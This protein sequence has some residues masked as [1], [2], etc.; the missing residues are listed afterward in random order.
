MEKTTTEAR[1]AVLSA[2]TLIGDRVVNPA[3]ENLGKIQELMVDLDSSR[4]A[5]AVLGFG[6]FLGL[7]QKLIAIPFQALRLDADRNGFILDIDKEKLERAPAFDKRSSP[8]TAV[9]TWGSQI[10]GYYGY[11]PYWE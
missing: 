11:R 7:R 9:R 2:R 4:I 8:G 10:H 3:G 1:P 5:Y 6:G